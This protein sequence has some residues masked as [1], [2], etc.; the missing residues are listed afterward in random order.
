VNMSIFGHD[1]AVSHTRCVQGRC[2][3][4]QVG[5]YQISVSVTL[6]TCVHR[7]KRRSGVS[8]RKHEDR[9]NSADTRIFSSGDVTFAKCPPLPKGCA[10]TGSKSHRAATGYALRLLRNGRERGALLYHTY[11]SVVIGP[12]VR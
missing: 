6:H 8:Y 4:T 10:S 2:G 5:D 9:G 3:R 11:A 1:L 12:R 7:G